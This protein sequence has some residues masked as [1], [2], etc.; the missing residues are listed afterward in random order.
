MFFEF[1]ADLI[2][3][4]MKQALFI[5]LVPSCL[6]FIT[7]RGVVVQNFFY[8]CIAGFLADVVIDAS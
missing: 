6:L 2:R 7:G 3:G 8:F 1:R 4:P 5:I